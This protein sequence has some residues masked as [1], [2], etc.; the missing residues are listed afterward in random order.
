MA[1]SGGA[2]RGAAG[3]LKG[4]EGPDAGPLSASRLRDAGSV[5]SRSP[6][7]HALGACLA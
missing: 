7:G 2:G 5:A 6:G 4:G 1:R 3:H